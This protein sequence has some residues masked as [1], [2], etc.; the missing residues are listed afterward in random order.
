MGQL[1]AG[2]DVAKTVRDSGVIEGFGKIPTVV[3]EKIPIGGHKICRR[4]GM[5]QR[6]IFGIHN[7]ENG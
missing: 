1:Y 6:R 4:Q 5:E 2:S 7:G 3:A